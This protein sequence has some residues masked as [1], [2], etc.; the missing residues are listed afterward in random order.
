MQRQSLTTIFY[1]SIS[2]NQNNGISCKLSVPFWLFLAFSLA[3]IKIL[4][5]DFSLFFSTT[6]QIYIIC[7]SLLSVEWQP[8][9]SFQSLTLEWNLCHRCVVAC[10]LPQ[11]PIL[12]FFS[13]CFFFFCFRCRTVCFREFS[14]Q[15]FCKTLFQLERCFFN[16]IFFRIFLSFGFAWSQFF[17]VCFLPSNFQ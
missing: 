1:Y 7:V 4:F 16:R 8:W 12:R 17:G 15:E 9:W 2:I 11:F 14:T 13:V 3:Y 10:C 6:P 5:S